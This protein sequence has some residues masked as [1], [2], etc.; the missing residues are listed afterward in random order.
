MVV[1]GRS[2]R[3]CP[4]GLHERSGWTTPHVPCGPC[5][6]E[7]TRL[8]AAAVLVERLP[9]LSIRAALDLVSSTADSTQ[10]ARSLAR[11]FRSHADALASGSS[12]APRAVVKLVN[13]LVDAKVDGGGSHALRRV[14]AAQTPPAGAQPS[15]PAT[16]PGSFLGNTRGVPCTPSR[17][18]IAFAP[19]VYGPQR[20]AGLL[21]PT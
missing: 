21:S 3:L 14:W 8:D 2:R 15:L 6:S 9:S 10:A 16:R 1:P 17:W 13:V 4:A 18:R 7:A 19:W 12:D 20:P 11:H 5:E